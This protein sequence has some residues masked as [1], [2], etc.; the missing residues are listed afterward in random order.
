MAS[1][2]RG[3]TEEASSE[4]CDIISWTRSPSFLASSELRH[5]TSWTRNPSFLASRNSEEDVESLLIGIALDY[6]N[7]AATPAN[8]IDAFKEF[9]L[10]R[11][12]YK[13]IN[14]KTVS[15]GELEARTEQRI[16]CRSERAWSTDEVKAI[17]NGVR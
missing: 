1:G 17:V 3:C 12:Y 4:F 16:V 14:R 5:I 6:W 13:K 2:A 7:T 10:C 8:D 11:R 9:V 15:T